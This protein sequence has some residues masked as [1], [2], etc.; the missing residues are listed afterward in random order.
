M[1]QKY[2]TAKYLVK[3]DEKYCTTDI[4]EIWWYEFSFIKET[5]FITYHS[6]SYS[7]RSKKNEL[8]ESFDTMNDFDRIY[9]TK[10]SAEKHCEKFRIKFTT[11]HQQLDCRNNLRN[12]TQLR[13]NRYMG[14]SDSIYFEN[15][16]DRWRHS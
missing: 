12:I 16:A 3:I 7:Y 9:D 11:Y 6:Y 2:T 13:H 4:I 10:E 1:K 8:M 5:E 15:M 14:E